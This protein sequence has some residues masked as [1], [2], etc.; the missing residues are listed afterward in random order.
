MSEE[1]DEEDKQS[2]LFL[3]EDDGAL[4]PHPCALSQNVRGRICK[5]V[6]DIYEILCVHVWS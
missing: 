2:S 1:D 6:S 5:P 4:L 3:G